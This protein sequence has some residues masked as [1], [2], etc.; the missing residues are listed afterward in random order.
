MKRKDVIRV[1]VNGAGCPLD[2]AL[3]YA[4]ENRL[5]FPMMNTTTGPVV[6]VDRL[7]WCEVKHI[8]YL[9]ENGRQVLVVT[10]ER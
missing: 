6:A 4:M 1:W 8:Q 2:Q 7:N 10:V 5:P 3:H 9:V